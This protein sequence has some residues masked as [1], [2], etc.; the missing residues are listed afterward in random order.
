[1]L[2]AGCLQDA[3]PHADRA[4]ALALELEG[5]PAVE[6]IDELVEAIEVFIIGPDPDFELRAIWQPTIDKLQDLKAL[7]TVELRELPWTST[8]ALGYN[9]AAAPMKI[10]RL[11]IG[12]TGRFPRGRADETDEG[13]LKLAITT[14]KAN[15]IVRLIFGKQVTW[16]GLPVGEARQLAQMLLETAD[17]I[18]R[19]KA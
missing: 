18:E 10:P 8:E 11:N 15:G 17:E 9:N 6:D 16:I 12:P 3:I 4:L 7:R 13:E 5:R 2:D 1:M 19:S 14:D